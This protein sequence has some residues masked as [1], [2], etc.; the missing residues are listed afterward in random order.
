[1]HHE[2]ATIRPP[3]LTQIRRV[4]PITNEVP[5]IGRAALIDLAADALAIGLAPYKLRLGDRFHAD[6][7]AAEAAVATALALSD[8]RSDMS[9]A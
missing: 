7:L 2:P 5:T 4:H 3:G 1:M 6:Q 8:I 9:I